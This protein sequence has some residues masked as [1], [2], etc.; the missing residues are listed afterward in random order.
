[1]AEYTIA[2]LEQKFMNAHNAG[3]TR[4]AKLL[5]NMIVE[6]DSGKA[7][8]QKA[9]EGDDG[10]LIFDK[11][12]QNE[13]Y[14]QDLKDDFKDREGTDFEGDVNDLK[15]EN[16]EYWNSSLLNELSLA[17]TGFDIARMDDK[18]KERTLRMFNTYDQTNITGEGSRSLWEQTKDAG[19]LAWAPSTW[20]G[21]K[22]IAGG[23]M[24]AAGKAG[25]KK[26]LSGIGARSAL[27][28]GAITGGMDVAQQTGVEMQLDD[29]QEFDVGRT[30]I[31]TGLGAGLGA[32]AP[33]L[34]KGAGKVVEGIGGGIRGTAKAIARPIEAASKA[35][36][37]IVKTFGGGEA[38]TE[39][40]VQ[41]GKRVLD[42]AVG[43]E[44]KSDAA[45]SLTESLKS[46]IKSGREKFTQ[47]FDD[48]GEIE[49][50][51]SEVQALVDTLHSKP[52][53]SKM[54]NLQDAVD[55]M[56]AGD[57]TPTQALRKVR[58]GLGSEFNK[59]K[60]GVGT[61]TS[62]DQ[63]LGTFYKNS[64][65]LFTKAASKAGKGKLASE[66]DK[67]YSKFIGIRGKK[68]IANA[69][70]DYSAST[71]KLNQ[72]ITSKDPHKVTEFLDEMDELAKAAG[73]PTF[74]KLQRENLQKALT[75]HLFTGQTG[76][77]LKRFLGDKSGVETLQ[78]VFEDRVAKET[79]QGFADI[80][81]NAH[82]HKGIGLFMS[83]LLA[84][85]AGAMSGGGPFGAAGGFLAMEKLIKSTPFQKLS[86]KVFSGDPHKKAQA[87]G[88]LGKFLD[89]KGYNAVTAKKVIDMMIGAGT[90]GTGVYQARDVSP[91][92]VALEANSKLKAGYSDLQQYFK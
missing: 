30:A 9:W 68:S 51:K 28:G 72:A 5:K 78:K 44:G 47:R 26:L 63:V 60:R 66:L 19:D 32:V 40:V 81:E 79:W 64:R 74:A 89:N 36:G 75:E 50:S 8:E 16:F 45:E 55:L 83:K 86:M 87:L 48:L 11:L 23:A 77:P 54:A 41:E 80:L 65:N 37:G 84:G 70:E 46:V 53:V 22:F 17:D 61:N 91:E 12:D 14:V 10:G 33:T 73:D 67:D 2:E 29:D 15:E 13:Q 20:L 7:P 39:G 52:G 76:A 71:R 31:A 59:A 38:A 21:G 57:L 35:R 6:Q 4:A 42:E 69:Q 49:V 85:A 90:V 24:H 25:I 43:L 58:S 82:D 18:Q 88:A 3:D 62:A 1:M 34:I 56:N 27:V 92:E